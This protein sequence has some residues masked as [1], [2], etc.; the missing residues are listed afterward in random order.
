MIRHIRSKNIK[1]NA[2]VICVNELLDKN[3]NAKLECSNCEHA[4]LLTFT[5]KPGVLA[6]S[7]AKQKSYVTKRMVSIC[8][9]KTNR[10]E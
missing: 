10:H 2:D 1:L 9:L 3:P 6:F 7:C 8:T 4:E 5:V